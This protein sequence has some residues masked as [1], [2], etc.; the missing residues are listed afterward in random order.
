MR[1]AA[2]KV[3]ISGSLTVRRFAPAAARLQPS[4]S[5]AHGSLKV[6]TI[7]GGLA[8]SDRTEFAIPAIFL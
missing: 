4:L 8:R 3:G 2:E 7:A 5:W 1:S 6:A